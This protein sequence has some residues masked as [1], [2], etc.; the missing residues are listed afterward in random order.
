MWK[1]IEDRVRTVSLIDDDYLRNSQ[2]KFQTT[3]KQII[4]I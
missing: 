4:I 2:K 1:S 3:K